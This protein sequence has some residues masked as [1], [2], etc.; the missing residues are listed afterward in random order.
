MPLTELQISGPGR[1]VLAIDGNYADRVFAH[2][3]GAD[4]TLRIANLAL[5]HGFSAG[6]GGCIFSEGD[7]DIAYVE[8]SECAAGVVTLGAEPRGASRTRGGALA[9]EGSVF[10]AS[11]FV[12]DSKVDG[13]SGY[14]Y[15]GGVSA[16]HGLLL[17]DSTVS[18]NFATSD[19]GATYG[20]GI[21]I[22]RRDAS[23]RGVL[24]SV[25]S[26]IQNNGAFSHCGFCPVRGGGAFVYGDTAFGPGSI[27]GNSA[28]SDAHYG[29]GGG[30]YFRGGS[31]AGPVGASI[32]DT[33][34]GSNSADNDGGAIGAA[35][36]LQIVRG[37]ISGNSARAGGA[38][39]QLAGQLWLL[40]S[41]LTGNI[42]QTDGGA[43]W[44]F[45]YGDVTVLNSTISEIIAEGNCGAFENSF[46]SVNL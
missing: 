37:T 15:G 34:V 33:D 24:T 9:A 2:T 26:T 3:A 43:I 13:A 18:G 29:A 39:L 40:D 7:V 38:I 25:R 31:G 17:N 6:D 45:G 30:L 42:A 16:V 28:F 32:V 41:L 20:G 27:S 1:N 21:S 19:G 11:S 5:H 14:A 23:I 44:Q 4:A 8:L 36:D 46:G 10:I 12:G 35:G 22:G